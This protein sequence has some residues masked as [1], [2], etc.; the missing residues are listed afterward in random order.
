MI[1]VMKASRLLMFA[2]LVIRRSAK[3]DV[4]VLNK[5]LQ[6][7]LYYIQAWHLVYFDKNPFD[8]NDLPEAWVHGP[9]YPD[10]FKTYKGNK[11]HPIGLDK[12]D[13]E[14]Q[15]TLAID[16]LIDTLG[17]SDH[18]VKFLNQALNFYGKM[19]SFELE[20]ATHNEQPWL[21]ARVG[22]DAKD[23]SDN[24]ISLDTMKAFYGGLLEKKAA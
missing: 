16:K 22:L 17:L 4:E 1:N 23:P 3:M 7:L 12:L 24:K 19:S 5:K 10:V 18:Q 2:E 15:N 8:E 11:F 21:D 6:K 9:V 14:N 13:D 20:N